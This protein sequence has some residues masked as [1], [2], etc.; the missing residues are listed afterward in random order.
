MKISVRDFYF[1]LDTTEKYTFILISLLPITFLL[2]N[3]FINLF[4]M[5]FGVIFLINIFI[6]KKKI[7]KDRIFWIL[8][9]LFFS[10]LLNVFFSTNS[11]NSLPR[12]MKIL[13]MIAFINDFRKMAQFYK[14]DFEITIFKIWSFIFLIIVM[15]G[16]FEFIF[17]FNTLGFKSYIP[18]RIAGFFGSE[19]VVGAF[20]LGFVLLFLSYLTLIIK[21]TKNY[22]VPLILISLI[23]ISFLLGERSNFIKVFISIL[24]FSLFA[25]EINYKKK[26]FSLIVIFISLLTILNLSEMHKLRFYS[27]LIPL[28]KSKNINNYLKESQYG[29]HYDTAIKIF[30]EYPIFGVGIKN[31]RYESSKDKYKNKSF[32]YNHVRQA[33]HPHQIH[34]EFLSET[35]VFGYSAFIIFLLVSFYFGIKNYIKRKN[36]FQLS[37]MVFVFSSIVPLIPSGSFFS[38]FSG[39][40]FWINYAVMV[41]YIQK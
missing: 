13:L 3:F 23:M 12:V 8:L 7:I 27:Q 25:F 34:L 24:L 29:A 10:L 33:T 19:L 14:K 16:L 32:K 11:L 31:F 38:T 4:F 41:A 39:G 26:I 20:Y 35:G 5:L 9:F 37:G 21:N 1:K 18:G 30:Y 40:L 2:G 17:G 22:T 36:M 15:D 28:F 6:L